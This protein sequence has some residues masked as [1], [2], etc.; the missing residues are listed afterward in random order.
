MDRR[1]SYQHDSSATSS[2][3]EQSDSTP[4]PR[5]INDPEL[6]AKAAQSTNKASD[7]ILVS[8]LC[9]FLAMGGFAFGYDTGSISGYINMPNFL[10]H[11][12]QVNEDNEYYF[13]KVRSGLIVSMF[14][15]GAVIGCLTSGKVADNYGRKV[16]IMTC[17]AIYIV[18]NLIQICSFDAW[19]QVMIGR[20]VG[21]VGI[22]GFS[23]CVPMFQSETAPKD[24]R[25]TLVSSFQLF[26]TLGIFIGYCVCYGTNERTDTGAW[27][28]PL[29]LTFLWALILLIGVAFMPE[30]PRYLLSKDRVDEALK[31][32]CYV[33]KRDSD[34][35]LIKLS[36]DEIV[37]AI[38]HERDV[39]T[40]GWGQVFIGNP[41]IGYRTLVGFMIQVLQ[42]LCGANYF[43]Y[44]GTSI[45]KAIGMENSFATSMIF[46]AV[47]FVS[48]FVSFY[49]VETFGRR[50][51]LFWGAIAM[52][53]FFVIYASLGTASLYPNGQ[54]QPSDPQVGKGMIAVTCFFIFSFAV[55]WAPIAFVYCSE[56]YPLRVKSKCI[57]MATTGNWLFNFLISL[58]TPFIT[59]AISFKYGYVFSGCLIFAAF[60]V[61]FCVHE[62][63]G[64]TLEQIDQMYASRVLPWMSVQYGKDI[65]NDVQPSAAGYESKATAEHGTNSNTN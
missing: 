22:G 59:G 64:L 9:F 34:D 41:R 61:F 46:G 21:G 20:I 27:R 42:Q 48:T 63:K 57:G 53:V 51:C 24:I 37:A 58:F 23:V 62:T 10:E 54:S 38:E 25:G 44:Y 19:Y 39:G 14:S 2:I 5:P 43:F 18:G 60:F 47:N 28:I 13:S 3:K 36:M 45:F 33:N 12:G 29:G 32:M 49:T 1:G 50:S 17:A 35:P 56:I 26:V 15:I 40:A 6:K 7:Y 65:Y 55:S 8:T 30:S 16:A 11:F 31:S 4:P 52:F